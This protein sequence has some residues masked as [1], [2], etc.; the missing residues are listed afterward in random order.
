MNQLAMEEAEK[1][2][3]KVRLLFN[4]NNSNLL[5]FSAQFAKEI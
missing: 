2:K 3:S 1:G 4:F 5:S